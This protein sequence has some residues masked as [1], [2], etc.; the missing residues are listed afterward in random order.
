MR[1]NP[2]VYGIVVVM[3]FFGII[4]GFQSAGFWTTSGKVSSQGQVIQ[5]SADD[6]NTIKG[7]MTMNQI[8]ATYPVSLRE[9][10]EVF[11]LPSDTNLDTALKDLE[12]DTFSLEEF[13]P[14]LQERI[15]QIG[16]TEKIPTIIATVPSN[17][18]SVP[19]IAF[20]PTQHVVSDNTLTGKTTFQTVLDWGVSKDVIQTIIG[21]EITD[22]GLVIKDYLA[23]L[24]LEFS[25]IKPLLQA[26]ID[27]VN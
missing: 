20:D 10:I 17:P 7:W 21:S 13:R 6:V 11:N 14:W 8:I 18:T 26:E 2:M 22:N 15:L 16:G 9:I 19:V 12:S 27:K 4:Y 24:G 5:P 25:T 3:V 1:I 23:T